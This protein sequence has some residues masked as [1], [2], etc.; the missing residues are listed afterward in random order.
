MFPIAG[1]TMAWGPLIC[2]WRHLLFTAAFD[3]PHC[4]VGE[5]CS[6][7]SQLTVPRIRICNRIWVSFIKKRLG[8]TTGESFGV[9][10]VL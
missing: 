5:G 8:T 10:L 1:E 4:A 2:G 3:Q 6:L 9:H 7:A